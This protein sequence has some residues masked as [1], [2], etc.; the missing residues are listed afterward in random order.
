MLQVEKYIQNWK[1]NSLINELAYNGIQVFKS[2]KVTTWPIQVMI[3]ELPF[4]D[5][6][7]NILLV[8]GILLLNLEW[9]HF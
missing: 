5:R 1:P 3:N 9:I 2:S 7:S 8:Y 6:K 4:H